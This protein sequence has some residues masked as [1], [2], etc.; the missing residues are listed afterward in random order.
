VRLQVLSGYVLGQR[1]KSWVLICPSIISLVKLHWHCGYSSST[2]CVYLLWIK[3]GSQEVIQ[4]QVMFATLKTFSIHGLPVFETAIRKIRYQRGQFR[5]FGKFASMWQNGSPSWSLCSER[6]KY[7]SCAVFNWLTK[8]RVILQPMKI[9]FITCFCK[10]LS[11]F[12]CRQHIIFVFPAVIQ[13]LQFMF[14]IISESKSQVFG[15]L[16]DVL[17]KWEL[18]TVGM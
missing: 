14:Y 12:T 5:Y 9:Q 8:K 4:L 13:L 16:H 6:W 15:I 17:S 11:W 18:N 1:S 7:K 10:H 3:S 2:V